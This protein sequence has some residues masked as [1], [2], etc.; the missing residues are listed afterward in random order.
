MSR[1]RSFEQQLFKKNYQLFR[2]AGNSKQE[3]ETANA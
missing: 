1:G 3:E 2:H